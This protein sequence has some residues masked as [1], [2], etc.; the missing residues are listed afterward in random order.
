M[1][2]LNGHNFIPERRTEIKKKKQF[3][4]R[5]VDLLN[6]W[7]KLRKVFKFRGYVAQQPKW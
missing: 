7:V 1:S 5:S 2:I 3:E 4:V 6:L